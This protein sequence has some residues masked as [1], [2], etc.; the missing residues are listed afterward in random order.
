M[1]MP[2]AEW[3]VNGSIRILLRI[4]YR[5]DDSELDRIPLTGPGILITN[6]TTNFEGPVY[7]AL[8]DP[9]EKTALGKR[10]LWKNPITRFLMQ[11]WGVI[12]LDR[13]GADRAA[14]RKAHQVLNEGQFLG[15]APEG[16][17]S[18]SGKLRK[19]RPGA[20][21]LATTARVP[22]YPM[23]QWGITDLPEN[24]RRL[25]RTPLHFRV[26]RPFLL[27]APS[28]RAPNRT[29]LRTMTDELMYQLAVLLPAELRGHYADLSNMTER[30]ITPLE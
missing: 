8:L 24:L 28:G 20:A 16:T 21:L 15:V 6:H 22:M 27:E 5:L 14:L 25:R 29:E 11:V 7:Y 2:A 12:P 13:R 3:M 4:L 30:Y 10:E 17:R 19:G 23:V 18:S 1:K 9:R 26:G